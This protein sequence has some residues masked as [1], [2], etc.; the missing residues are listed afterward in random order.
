MN[1]LSALSAAARGRP[2]HQQNSI[3]LPR[4]RENPFRRQGSPTPVRHPTHQRIDSLDEARKYKQPSK[5][6]ASRYP[7][8]ITAFSVWRV[9][10][11]Y[12]SRVTPLTTNLTPT[13]N[14]MAHVEGDGQERKIR[15][16]RKMV[17]IPSKRT[18]PE[19]GRGRSWEKIMSSS[20]ASRKTIA[21]TRN[22]RGF[23]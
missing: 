9:V 17:A 11:E 4:S 21:A 1:V 8:Q 15:Y 18:H 2:S 3:T 16:A 7:H 6:L 13:R 23:N 12:T 10:T 5:E 20:R 22:V 14:P 19:P